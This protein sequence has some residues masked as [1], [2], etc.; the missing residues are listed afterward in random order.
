MNQCA[1]RL[2]PRDWF[3]RWVKLVALISICQASNRARGENE[4]AV[5][6]PRPAWNVSR[7]IGSPE[8]PPPYTVEPVLT[9]IKW[10]NPVFA[11]REPG[12]EWLVIVEWP[13]LIPDTVESTS[14]VGGKSSPPRYAPV[15]ATRVIDRAADQRSEPFLE[16]KDRAIYCVEFHPHYREDGQIFI[17]SRTHPEGGA[18]INYLSRFVVSRRTKVDHDKKPACDA[19]SEER[20]LE[21]PSEG[22]DGGAAVFGHD[23]MLYVSTG[24]GTADSDNNV[25]A[26]DAGNLL[27]KILRIDVDHPSAGK[28]YAIP[29]DNP[30]LDLKG[31]RGEIWSLG[32]RNP[33]R[34]TVDAKTGALW[35][36]N[37]GQDL[38]EFAH[39]I[40]RGDNCGWSIYEGSHPFY[41]NRQRGPGKLAR[42]T[43]EHDHGAFRSLTGGVVYYG[44]RHPGLEGAYVYG[45]YSTG[46]I[47]SV[48]HDGT[49]VVWNREVAK[50]TLNIVGFATS[51][52][53]ELLVVDYTTGV[54]RLI[55]SPPDDSYRR[56]PHRLSQTGLFASV[57]EHRPAPGVVPYIAKAPGW[58]DGAVAERLVALPG[59][60]SIERRPSSTP[61]IPIEWK[62]P[63]GAV[64]V[65]TLLLPTKRSQ[66]GAGRRIETR[67]LTKQKGAWAGYSYVWNDAQDDATL[68]AADGMDVHLSGKIAPLNGAQLASQTWRVPSRVECMSCHSRQANFVLGLS[69]PQADCNQKYGGSELNQLRALEQQKVIG[70][71]DPPQTG[72]RPKLVNPYD[73]S[74]DLEARVRSYLHANCSSCHVEAGGGNSRIRLNIEQKRDQM[75]LVD[76]YPQHDTFGLPAALIVAPGEPQRSVLYHRISRRGPGQM[77]PRGTQVVDREAVE[78]FREWIAKLPPQRKFVKEWAMDDLAPALNQITHGRSYEAGA[79]AFKELG[80]LQCHRFAGSGGGAGPDLSGIAKKQGVRDLLES[81][82]E[83]S[84]K[85]ATEFA[86]TIVETTDGKTHEGRVA[87]EDN[88]KLILHTAGALGTPVTIPKSEIEKRTLSTVSTMPARLLNTLEKSEILDLLAYLVA[89]GDAKHAAFAK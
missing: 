50:T 36:G 21:W 23:G 86:A 87:H 67:I 83:P 81:I 47:R 68:V 51:H 76:V 77:P 60:S 75:Q 57:K 69:E 11:I 78:M 30:F 82:L 15:R 22:H 74:Q 10:K 61:N 84:K 6:S 88:E 17:C 66:E 38:W 34:M 33:W 45:D 18:G 49:K 24:D 4:K 46:A 70:K 80:C 85:I 56:F 72:E 71:I 62:F 25:T 20:I 58:A 35:V 42:P 43:V 54:Y 12:S 3:M 1:D 14:P 65:Q 9:Q 55:E 41:L 52:R 32:H 31:A 8:P 37:N 44:R 7:V 39:L 48:L 26:Q 73:R 63:E 89:D 28:K 5:L 16:L 79:R 59:E 29:P 13:Q 53:E 40:Q 64:L 2:S 19:A 27:G